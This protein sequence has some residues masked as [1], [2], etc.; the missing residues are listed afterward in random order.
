M[1]KPGR[2]FSIYG[3]SKREQAQ[4]AAY[5]A[6]RQQLDEAAGRVLDRM[7]CYPETMDDAIEAVIHDYAITRQALLT[8][9]GRKA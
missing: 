2:D 1:K 9:L 3:D 5:E 4:G 7:G 6:E 8:H